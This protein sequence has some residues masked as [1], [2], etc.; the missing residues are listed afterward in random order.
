MIALLKNKLKTAWLPAAVGAALLIAQRLCLCISAFYLQ[1]AAALFFGIC[2]AAVGIRADVRRL[3]YGLNLFVVLN[4]AFIAVG[5]LS[6]QIQAFLTRQ[7]F[8]FWRSVFNYDAPMALLVLWFAVFSAC[9]CYR[10]WRINSKNA[11]LHRGAYQSFFSSTAAVFRVY[12][13]FL[14]LYVFLIRR[15]IRGDVVSLSTLNLIPF[16]ML[17]SYF[18]GQGAGTYQ[19]LVIFFG[20]VFL[21]LPMGFYFC[22]RHASWGRWLWLVPVA[23]S[24]FVEITQLITR[25]GQC[26]IDD[27]LL[28][29]LGFY[30]GMWLKMGVDA[31]CRKRTCG[32]E[33]TIFCNL[34]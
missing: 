32:R 14:L 19:I 33:E 31:L 22:W 8:R 10:L 17:F 24:C 26:D 15:L 9:V 4:L 2:I 13:L 27:V 5:E 30:L 6:A 29:C 7:P 28:N 3:G 18:Q 34:K 25:L 11:Q 1:I 20:N 21:F 16:R 23:F 12:Y